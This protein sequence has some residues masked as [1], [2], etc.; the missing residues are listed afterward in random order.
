[1]RVGEQI[2]ERRKELQYTQKELAALSGLTQVHLCRI[3]QR[4]MDRIYTG[5]L[6]KVLRPLGLSFDTVVLKERISRGE[7]PCTNNRDYR[8]PGESDC[9]DGAFGDHD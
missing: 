2:R 9:N 8:E 7:V 1:M 3:E 5:T 6:A 4:G